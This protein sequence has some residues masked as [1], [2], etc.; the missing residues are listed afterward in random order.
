M[1]GEYYISLIKYIISMTNLEHNPQLFKIFEIV[2]TIPESYFD[3]LKVI[4]SLATGSILL[5]TIFL[6]DIFENPSHKI[7]I[8][9]SM[10]N[11]GLCI[12]YALIAIILSIEFKKRLFKIF[13]VIE[14]DKK[15][16]FVK[17]F[18]KMKKHYVWFYGSVVISLINFFVGILLI[19]IFFLT[20]WD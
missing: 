15:D 11:F 20:N 3:F 1:P 10:I 13:L 6:K 19:G 8:S 17:W 16:A 4:I 14:D 2:G 12:F 18:V 5:I 9:L 7:L